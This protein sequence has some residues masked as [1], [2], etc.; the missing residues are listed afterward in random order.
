MIGEFYKRYGLN[1]GDPLDETQRRGFNR[2]V[3]GKMFCPRM[4]LAERMGWVVSLAEKEKSRLEKFC[5]NKSAAKHRES[6][7]FDDNN[8]WK[9]ELS[10]ACVEFAAMKFYGIEHIFDYSI[11]ERSYEK[12]HPDFLPYV[13]CGVKGSHV[14]QV[15][16]VKK[17]TKPYKCELPPFSGRLFRCA[18]IIGVT[19]HDVVWLLGI[20]SPEVLSRCVDDNLFITNS[21]SAK[22]G[23]YGALELVDIPSSIE[24]LFKTTNKMLVAV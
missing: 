20:A 1:V 14:D 5:K 4:D 16:L 6:R 9:R 21:N 22:T 8:R 15:P 10:G 3:F 11:T 2:Y 17:E 24:E 19:D 13:V 18:D 7:G 12:D 23:F